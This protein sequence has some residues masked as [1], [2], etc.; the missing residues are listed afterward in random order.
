[1]PVLRLEHLPIFVI[2]NSNITVA[3]YD[4]GV[5]VWTGQGD[6]EEG[7]KNNDQFHFD[8]LGFFV[9]FTFYKDTVKR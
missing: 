7:G 1:M 4:C 2:S 3:S 5:L 6:G 9:G 8:G